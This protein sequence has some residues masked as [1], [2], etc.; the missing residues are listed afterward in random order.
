MNQN[1]CV[2]FYGK[3]PVVGDFVSRR[4]PRSFIEFWDRWLQD[5]IA[6][7]RKQLAEAWLDLYLVSPIWR[8]SLSSGICGETAWTGI[9][10]PSVD[11]VGRYFPLTLV[12]AVPECIN[13]FLLARP[14]A[15]RWYKDLEDTALSMLE[16]DD[17]ELEAF[18]LSV[19][20]ISCD[21]ILNLQDTVTCRCRSQDAFCITLDSVARAADAFPFLLWQLVSSAYSIWWTEGSNNVDSCLLVCDGLPRTESYSSMLGGEWD[22]NVWGLGTARSLR[23]VSESE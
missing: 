14:Q 22:E 17:L 9:L 12:L 19:K 16:R 10:M 1:I 4:V 6:T 18:D 20:E 5:A 23:P 7:S 21:D 2:G 15:D 3:V 11:K 8:F 13:P